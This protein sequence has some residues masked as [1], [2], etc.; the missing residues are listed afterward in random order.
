MIPKEKFNYVTGCDNTDCENIMRKK[1]TCAR[2]E[3][4]N[5][6]LQSRTSNYLFLVHTLSR[7]SNG[8]QNQ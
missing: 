2:D 1:K 3:D 4:D 6:L 5:I 8:Y 7:T